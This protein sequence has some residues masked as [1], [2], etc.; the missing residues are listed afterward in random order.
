MESFMLKIATDLLEIFK[1]NPTTL[2]FILFLLLYIYICLKVGEKIRTHRI[3]KE[4]DKSNRIDISIELLS[5][6]YFTISDFMDKKINES[7]L[8]D[9]MIQASAHLPK[10]H[11]LRI[12]DWEKENNND[13]IPEIK[14]KVFDQLKY[15]KLIQIQPVAPRHQKFSDQFDEI[16]HALDV[17]YFISSYVTAFIMVSVIITILIIWLDKVK[18]R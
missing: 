2:F 10:D 1:K 15:L 11:L 3:S 6:L 13:L 14:E 8:R 18:F 12:I 9:V 5:R 17:G 16:V 4:K 7:Q